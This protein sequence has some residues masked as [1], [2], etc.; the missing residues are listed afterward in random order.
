MAHESLFNSCCE[1]FIYNCRAC[2]LLAA[3]RPSR[4]LVTATA[5]LRALPLPCWRPP[6][7]K[8]R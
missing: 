4:H 5:V 6:A 8:Y 3:A 1:L 2:R 7:L